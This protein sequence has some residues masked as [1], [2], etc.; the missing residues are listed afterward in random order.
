MIANST[1]N[2][3]DLRVAIS[4]NENATPTTAMNVPPGS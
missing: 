3:V 2:S 4:D 1:H